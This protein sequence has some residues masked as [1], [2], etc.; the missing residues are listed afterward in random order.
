M[1]KASSAASRCVAWSFN[2]QTGVC[3]L[4]AA[5]ESGYGSTENR[6]PDLCCD[7][8][9]LPS[10]DSKI[11]EKP[12]KGPPTADVDSVKV[13]E[14]E[15]VEVDGQLP[16]GTK[17]PSVEGHHNKGHRGPPAYL[18]A[19]AAS[20]KKLHDLKKMHKQ[21]LMSDEEFTAAKNKVTGQ[22]SAESKR[23]KK[24]DEGSSATDAKSPPVEGHHNKGH[25]G[26][27]A[28][29]VAK[30]ASK[31][32]LRDLKKM[33]QQGL[34][35]DEEFTAAKNNLEGDQITKA[36]LKKELHDLKTMHRQGLMSDEEFTAAKNKA[37]GGQ[38]AP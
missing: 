28:Y 37:K 14:T 7:S 32:K 10:S 31:K 36:T 11:Q 30:A 22:P 9:V 26:P 8:G 5:T 2:K 18:V 3:Y 21:G 34:M 1:S 17:S 16:A 27:P 19:K 29:L 6:T 15:S 38:A 12:D 13:V 35:S 25:R 23:Q 20:K 33:H 24:P 4:L